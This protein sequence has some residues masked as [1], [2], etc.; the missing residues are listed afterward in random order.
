[1]KIDDGEIR[2]LPI[3]DGMMVSREA[4]EREIR[5]LRQE[6]DRWVELQDEEFDALV[7]LPKEERPAAY[8]KMR[9]MDWAVRPNKKRRAKKG[10]RNRRRK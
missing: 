2:R 7:N 10:E 1:M 9:G 5:S 6:R 8:A 3:E 4:Y